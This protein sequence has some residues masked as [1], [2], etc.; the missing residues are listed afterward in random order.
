VASSEAINK[1]LGEPVDQLSESSVR[2][3]NNASE[4][5]VEYMLFSG[6]APITEPI[7]GTSGF[8]EVFAKGGP[9][10]GKGRSLRDLDLVSRIFRYPC[11][12]MIYSEAFDDM[13]AV[14]RERILRRVWEVLKGKDT[15]PAFKHLSPADRENI[16]EILSE[17]KK[18]LP[19]WW[20]S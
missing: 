4:E 7:R 5:L 13:P 9:H 16:F 6:E 18:N 19:S 17:T 11:S 14:A 8:T 20:R 1:A 15:A 10:D 3:I 2:R 12:Y